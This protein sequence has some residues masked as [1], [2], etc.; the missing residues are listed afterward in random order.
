MPPPQVQSERKPEEAVTPQA[1]APQAQQADGGNIVGREERIEYRD[2][3]GNLLNDDQVKAL[4]SEGKAKFE[5]KYETRTRL[6]DEAGNEVQPVAPP[7]PDVEGAEPETPAQP[8]Q[9]SGEPANASAVF[10]KWNE[11]Q[12]KAQPASDASEATR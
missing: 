1:N 12:N 6:V 10:S 4:M 11:S 3:N 9:K 2:Q 7:H 5:T 8:E